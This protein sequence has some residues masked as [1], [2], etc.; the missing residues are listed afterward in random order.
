MSGGLRRRMGRAV[1]AAAVTVTGSAIGLGA[2][3]IAA[4]HEPGTNGCTLS[5]DVGYVPV[6]YNFHRSCDRHDLCYINKLYGNSSAGR[7][8]C[9]DVFRSNMR[10]WCSGYYSSWYSA[11]L[12]GLC[13]GVADTYYSAVRSFGGWYF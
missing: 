7:K 5:P 11:P 8:T 12:R 1:A 6:Y 13:N 3:G 4:A 10:G 2:G 9:D